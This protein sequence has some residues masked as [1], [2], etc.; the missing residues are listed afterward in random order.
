[1]KQIKIF[2]LSE[3]K[4]VKLILLILGSKKK[5][6]SSRVINLIERGELSPF[7]LW[8]KSRNESLSFFFFFFLSSLFLQSL[9][10]SCQAVAGIF[11]IWCLFVSPMPR[12][13]SYFSSHRFLTL[14]PYL[15]VFPG[16]RCI[17]QV[18]SIFHKSPISL[19]FLSNRCCSTVLYTCH[20]SLP[21]IFITVVLHISVWDIRRDFFIKPLLLLLPRLTWFSS[22]ECNP[23]LNRFLEYTQYRMLQYRCL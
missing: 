5:L 18:C 23:G 1:M 9:L 10:K 11:Q 6:Y 22:K 17:F 16:S 12:Q 13:F 8:S 3:R 19:R 14:F 15:N 2:N 21:C 7:L 4:K 20:R